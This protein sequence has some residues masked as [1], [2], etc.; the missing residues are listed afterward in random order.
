MSH[1]HATDGGLAGYLAK[2][3]ARDVRLHLDNAHDVKTTGWTHDAL[4]ELHEKSHATALIGEKLAEAPPA[5]VASI[6]GDRSLYL[7][8]ANGTVY[9]L[10]PA[11]V[12]DEPGPSPA[13]RCTDQVCFDDECPFCGPLD[14]ELPCP[15]DASCRRLTVYYE[16]EDRPDDAVPLYRLTLSEPAAELLA[17]ITDSLAAERERCSA[18]GES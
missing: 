11:G 18:G 13:C 2:A 8:D 14:G 6:V 17:S 16:D 4:V 7:T 9:L 12:W 10:E 5:V 3:S 1:T 15:R